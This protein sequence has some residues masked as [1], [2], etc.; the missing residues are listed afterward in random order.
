MKKLSM[1]LL[2]GIAG[3][4]LLAIQGSRGAVADDHGIS[5]E[6]LAGNYAV[7]LQGSITIC[8]D[9]TPK[10]VDCKAVGAMAKP[11]TLL[12]VGENTRDANGNACATFTV[13]RTTLP[14][15]N[16]PPVVRVIRAVATVASYDPA[17]GTGDQNVTTYSGGT[18]NGAS[19]DSMGATATGTNRAHFAASNDGRRID[20]V[21]TENVMYVTGT[22]G[23][24][25][26]AF[27]LSAIQLR[28]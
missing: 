8:F 11:F 5:L 18:C 21:L 12:Q 4:A 28:Q 19:F 6:E 27:F 2:I 3:F 17:T 26:G 14:V 1:I 16:T 22:T 24:S 15:D 25:I 13:V 9:M 20:L 23:N 10:P 7:T